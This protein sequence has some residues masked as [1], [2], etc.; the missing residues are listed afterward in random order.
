MK[1]DYKTEFK[2]STSEIKQA[3]ISI[4]SMLNKSGEATLYFGILNDGTIYGQEIGK[5]TTRDIS[6]AIRNNIKPYVEN[7]IVV[8]RINKKDV[9]KVTAKGEDQPY[10][11]YGRYYIRSDDEDL[12]MDP[13]MLGKFFTSKTINYSKW[14]KEMTNHGLDCV[15]EDLLIK[16]M[17]EAYDCGRIK[18]I[19][20]DVETSLTKLG[21]CVDGKL[22]NAGYYLFSKEKPLTLKLATFPTEERNIFTD[23][24]NF[25]GN[26]FE[27]IEEGYNYIVSNIRWSATIPGLKRQEKP[28]IPLSAIREI[29]V[30]SFAHMKIEY[31]ESIQNQIYISANKIHVFNPGSLVS[32]SIPEQYAKGEK[33]PIIR[34]PLIANVLYRN[35]TIDSFGTGFERVFYACHKENIKYKYNNDEFGFTFE[36][37][38]K[39]NN[40]SMISDNTFKY[41]K[42][43]V[44][45]NE[46]K[47]IEL[48][49]YNP[50]L[51]KTQMA[52]Q[53][54]VSLATISRAISNLISLGSI[55]RIGANKNGHYQ[56]N[57]R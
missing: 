4:C 1:E 31:S 2:K 44:E 42:D 54:N 52:K 39:D 19:Y 17:S 13:N 30:N 8:E 11:A 27:C 3:I 24:R 15:D 22:N 20:K 18:E 47:I 49:E 14:E 7:N 28:E 41:E 51:T 12:Q 45:T 29:V 25:K 10:S 53:L 26:I 57:K 48:L 33:K 9:I 21:L 16:Y 32:D 5:N 50:Y 56:V 40:I 43:N 55:T 23:I 38:R 35:N 34:N 46:S 37:I 36:F 6:I